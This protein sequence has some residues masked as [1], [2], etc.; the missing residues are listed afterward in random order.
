MLEWRSFCSTPSTRNSVRLVRIGPEAA[1]VDVGVAVAIA[2]RNVEPRQIVQHGLQVQIAA[3][4][5]LLGRHDEDGRGRLH[6]AFV[7]L[8]DR[9]GRGSR[10]LPLQ[11][12][13]HPDEARRIV[14]A[15][16]EIRHD[17]EQ[18]PD[19]LLRRI[20]VVDRQRQLGAQRVRLDLFLLDADGR[21]GTW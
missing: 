3:P 2:P 11:L 1:L 14:E 15:G 5:D 20:D 9:A 6:Q 12:R 4:S 10:Q 8:G 16:R 7:H 21:R 13:D 19:R 18:R 17:A